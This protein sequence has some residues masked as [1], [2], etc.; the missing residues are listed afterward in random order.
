MHA[1]TGAGRKGVSHS[2]DY[3]P[4]TAVARLEQLRDGIRQGGSSLGDQDSVTD[5]QKDIG[6]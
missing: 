3:A 2:I 6:A 4:L 5:H 1:L